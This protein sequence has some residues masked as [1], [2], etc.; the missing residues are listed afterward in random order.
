[1]VLLFFLYITAIAF[2]VGAELNAVL[3]RRYDAETI[4]HLAAHPEKI[5][6]SHEWQEAI[7]Q[8][9]DLEQR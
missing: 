8:A 2:L 4:A 7:E 9:G 5:E 1:V 6:D 3:Q